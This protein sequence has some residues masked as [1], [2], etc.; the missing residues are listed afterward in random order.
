M[1]ILVCNDDGINARGLKVLEGIAK[2]LSNDV[3]VVAP[4]AEQS[5]ASHSITLHEPLR[6]RKI[7]NRRFAVRGTPTACVMF[8]VYQ[9]ISGS[10]PDLLL[11]GVNCGANLGDDVTYSGTVAAAMEGLVL[12]IP[13][14][15][16]SQSVRAK[17]GV[18]WS[19]AAH[20]APIILRQLV[21]AGW[22]KH[23]LININFPDLKKADVNG[24]RVTTQGRRVASDLSIVNRLDTRGTPYYWLGFRRQSGPPPASRTDLAAINSGY[25]SVTPLKID[26]THSG[27]LGHLRKILV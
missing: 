4:E 3:W 6:I 5:G 21:N 8:A 23:A 16:L 10:P 7:S 14:V 22:S 19:T 25:V 27:S 13:S 9:I 26:L 1:R 15:A 12:G 2:A 20:F 17:S 24:I 18:K 11:S